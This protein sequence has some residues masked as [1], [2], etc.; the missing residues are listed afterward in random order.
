[1]TDWGDE[2][3]GGMRATTGVAKIEI[4]GRIDVGRARDWMEARKV[5]LA[6]DGVLA[7]DDY[8]DNVAELVA[9]VWSA[10]ATASHLSVKDGLVRHPE[11]AEVVENWCDDEGILVEPMAVVFELEVE[12]AVGLERCRAVVDRAREAGWIAGNPASENRWMLHQLVP[13]AKDEDGCGGLVSYW[14]ELKP[15]D[16]GVLVWGGR[17]PHHIGRR[18]QGGKGVDTV[19]KLVRKRWHAWVEHVLEGLEIGG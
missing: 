1:M 5:A 12:Q 10:M 14:C 13:S 8:K 18:A 6:R 4:G 3:S 7:L 19:R 15:G 2:D 17:R 11:V 16:D 9:G